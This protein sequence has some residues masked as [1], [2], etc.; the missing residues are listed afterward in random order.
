MMRFIRLLLLSIGLLASSPTAFASGFIRDAE[1]EKLLADYSYPLFRAAGLN[2]NTVG[3]ALINNKSLNAFVANGQ[4]IY[5]HTGLILEAEDPNM[6]IGVIA[7]EI[8][9]IIGGHLSRKA[10]A[11]NE[12]QRPALVA[13]IL[14]LGSVLAGA[15]DVGLALITGGQH[16][17]Q[18]K[19]LSFN[20][21]QESS[22]DVIA[23]RLL[24]DTG[25]SPN[26]IIRLMDMLADQE[27][28]SEVS[29]DPYVRSHP[30]SRERVAN[31]TRGAEQSAYRNVEDSAELRH[32][33]KMAQ[34]KIRGFLEHPSTTLRRYP[35]RNTDMPSRYA[36]AIALHRRGQTD[37]ALTEI[38]GLIAET[39]TSPWFH[40]LKG[41][42]N[43]EAG[44]AADGLAA[45]EKS[46]A[47][48]PDQPLLLIGLAT[49]QL[50]LGEGSDAMSQ[51]F[52]RAAENNLRAA[53]RLDSTN[54]TAYFQLSKV[55]GQMQRVAY[56]EWAL[57]EY[58][59]L[60]GRREALKHAQRALKGLPNGSPEKIRTTDILQI[61]RAGQADR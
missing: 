21:A 60:L 24:E 14:G 53:L 45:Y 43:Y 27:V 17:V 39:P 19:F 26:G 34:A 11:I 16:V 28:L 38:E 55:F 9:H 20:R 13:T 59:A 48:A 15:P 35:T 46:V 50:S 56:A 1:I 25:Q 42:V 18:R 8:G 10:S 52:N 61:A 47:L 7:H 12:A 6:V 4:N 29:Q 41:Q 40:E 33:H 57:A 54:T 37:A 3:I 5:F 23:L 2:P 32:R 30:L 22:A 44:R 36:R 49:T 31:Y 51:E 58:Y